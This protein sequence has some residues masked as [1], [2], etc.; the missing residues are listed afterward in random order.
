VSD[1]NAHPLSQGHGATRLRRVLETIVS[2]YHP[3]CIEK[4]KQCFFLI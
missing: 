3:V 1:P 4:K 2:K